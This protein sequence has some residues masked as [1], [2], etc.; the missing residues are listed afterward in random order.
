MKNFFKRGL[1]LLMV[2]VLMTLNVSTVSAKQPKSGKDKNIVVY[3][4]N[5]SCYDA[6]GELHN[7]MT[8]GM[9]PWDKVTVIN[10]AFFKIGNDFKLVTTDEWADFQKEFEHSKGLPWSNDRGHFAEYKY[11]KSQYPNV[12]VLVSVGGWTCSDKF[13]EMAAT[14]E[15]RSIFVNSIVDFLKQ[16]PFIDGV[17]LDWE[18]PGFDRGDGTPYGP[19]DGNN[20]ITLLK[21]IREAYEKSGLKDKMLTI[22]LPA[23]YDK[24]KLADPSQLNKYVDFINL[25]TYDIHGAWDKIS[26]HQSP[27]YMNPFDKS[28][29][30]PVDVKNKYNVDYVVK[31]LTI[32]YKIPGYKLNIGSPYYSQG[33][34]VDTKTGH[35]GMFADVIGSAPGSLAPGQYPYFTLEKMEQDKAYKKFRDPFS[36]VPWLYNPTEGYV[37]TYEDERSVAAKCD[38]VNWNGLGGIMV[39]DI[40]YDNTKGFPLTTTVHDK[41]FSDYKC[42]EKEECWANN[43]NLWTSSIGR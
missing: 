40:T 29:T 28:P 24:I 36:K 19:E 25:M 26:G 14:S 32:Q 3:Y 16:Y 4:P 12:K 21:E 11:Y 30:S 27:L 43:I 5:W 15:K 13:H 20:Y 18:Y 1:P 17:D 8:V 41:L 34:K 6:T 42:K 23:G 22:A 10:H 31:L 38:Y 39:W 9:I 35:K 33:W 2:L 37:Y 7:S